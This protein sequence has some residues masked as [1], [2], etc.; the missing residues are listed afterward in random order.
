MMIIKK[1]GRKEEFAP[2]KILR[3]IAAASDEA[4]EPLTESDLN[5]ILA[6]FRQIVSGKNLI[7][8]RQVAI[9]VCGLLY[10]KS[11]FKTM[12]KYMSYQ[13]PQ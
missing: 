4:K 8:S 13:S 5:I 6:D 11:H 2:E 1:S 7:T 12:E 3:S 9:I 10:S